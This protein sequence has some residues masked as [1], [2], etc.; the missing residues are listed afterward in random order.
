M[1]D[2]RSVV[3]GKK[4]EKSI[5]FLNGMFLACLFV[6]LFCGIKLYE[7]QKE[8]Q[9]SKI[10]TEEVRDTVE[11]KEEQ[12]EV[13]EQVNPP[14]E[15][16]VDSTYINDYYTY[17]K[18][19]FMSVNFDE[20][21]K[22]NED[23]VGW[24]RVNGTDINYPIVQTQDNDYYLTHA[25]DHTS[26]SSGWIFADYR[27][28]LENYRDNTIIY[29][30]NRHNNTLF[31][32]LLNAMKQEWCDNKENRIIQVSTKNHDSMWQI[33]SVYT[34]DKNADY[35]NVYFANKEAHESYINDMKNRSHYNFET[36]VTTDDKILTLSTCTMDTKARVVVQAK[37]LKISNK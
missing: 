22:K 4:K 29:G 27:C 13:V 6:F 10:L 37:L 12:G 11:I 1:E 34:I 9:K 15:G 20:L 24:I 25:F 17:M 14:E 5:F 33:F 2:G 8:N 28:S 23:T 3:K 31:G 16:K 30:H 32:T 7:W 36:P 18:M 26:N 21:K 19:P 35:L